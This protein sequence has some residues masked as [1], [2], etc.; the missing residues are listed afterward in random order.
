MAV[1]LGIRFEQAFGLGRTVGLGG[2][3]RESGRRS[4]PRSGDRDEV[5]APEAKPVQPVD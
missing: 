3:T 5:A 4:S 1:I 2:V